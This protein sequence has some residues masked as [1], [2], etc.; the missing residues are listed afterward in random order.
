MAKKM[1][2]RTRIRPYLKRVRT[3]RGTK[4]RLIRGH[5]R[6]VI[7]AFGGF[8]RPPSMAEKEHLRQELREAKARW[9]KA[10][11]V[12]EG[13][14]ALEDIV[15]I[16]NKLPFDDENPRNF[17]SFSFDS[18]RKIRQRTDLILQGSDTLSPEAARKMAIS[19][20][21]E[22]GH[23]PRNLGAQP[24][25]REIRD[26]IR[27]LRTEGRIDRS[28]QRQREL[29]HEALLRTI[30][31]TSAAPGTSKIILEA[32]PE[33]TKRDFFKGIMRE[34]QK[35]N[36]EEGEAIRKKLGLLR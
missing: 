21:I 7:R 17:G 2:V 27:D 1:K 31:I 9:K 8:K 15:R 23:I 14:K 12:T 26:V 4:Q 22:L 36:R 29:E 11:G 25:V 33:S 24:Q 35:S 16:K 5:K 18:E 13:E 30:G 32:D 34:T 20:L 3:N 19:E 6:N 28:K 10:V